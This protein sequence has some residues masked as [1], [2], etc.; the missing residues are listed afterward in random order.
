[1]PRS[2]LALALL[3]ALAAPASAQEWMSPPPTSQMDVAAERV[4]AYLATVPN[5]PRDI[6][7]IPAAGD[8]PWPGAAPGDNIRA[9]IWIVVPKNDPEAKPLLMF[10]VRPAT[11][12][13][14]AMFLHNMQRHPRYK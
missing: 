2:F 10:A 13:V 11:G 12:E 8:A 4:R 6:L 3:C 9:E 1:M 14:Y 5:L 7:V